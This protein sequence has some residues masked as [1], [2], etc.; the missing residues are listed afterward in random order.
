MRGT[1]S[2]RL[3]ALVGASQVGKS[4]LINAL[5][6]KNLLPVGGSNGPCTLTAC[7]WGVDGLPSP[8]ETMRVAAQWKPAGELVE[9]ESSV[10]HLSRGLSARQQEDLR[11]RLH[12]WLSAEG[13]ELAEALRLGRALHLPNGSANTPEIITSLV[14]DWP[15]GLLESVF[16]S[17]GDPPLLNLVDLP[18]LG[19]GGGSAELTRAWISNYAD[20]LDFVVCVVRDNGLP[21]SVAR[22]LQEAWRNQEDALASRLIVVC[23]YLD[24]DL[25]QM[26]YDDTPEAAAQALNL[27]VSRRREATLNQARKMLDQ[28]LAPERVF[29]LDVAARSSRHLRKNP[30][31]NL[32]GELERLRSMLLD[33]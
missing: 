23:T 18:G 5:T 13:P 26:D 6:G 16:L 8:E 31:V 11:S 4:S 33:R 19:V 29:V 28:D 24:N 10:S 12:S 20:R 17:P 25:C 15:A 14:S 21:T 1:L 7:L 9:T 22:T 2:T 27:A 3:V 30:T 32:A